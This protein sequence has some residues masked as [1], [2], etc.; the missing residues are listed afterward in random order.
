MGCRYYETYGVVGC[1][2]LVVGCWLLVVGCWLLI[3]RN[4]RIHGPGSAEAECFFLGGG[5]G[6]MFQRGGLG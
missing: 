5:T 6:R 4:L 3:V 2:L 1:W